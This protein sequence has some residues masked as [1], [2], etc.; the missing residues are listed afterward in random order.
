MSHRRKNTKRYRISVNAALLVTAGVAIS[1]A[2]I[3]IGV[4]EDSPAN[5]MAGCF[6]I[7][8]T[9]GGLVAQLCFGTEEVAI[10]GFIVGGLLGVVIGCVLQGIIGGAAALACFK[11]FSAYEASQSNPRTSVVYER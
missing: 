9:I 5:T 7:G 1:L 10:K 8:G 11:Q 2:F 6:L 3:R 4:S